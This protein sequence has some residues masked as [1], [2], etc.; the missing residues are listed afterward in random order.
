MADAGEQLVEVP[1]GSSALKWVLSLLAVMYVA[2]SLYFLF[3][4]RERIDQVGKSQAASNGQIAELGKRM[5][6]AEADSEALAKQ[7]GM[8]KKELADRSTEL[9]RQQH[10][11]EQRLAEEQKQEA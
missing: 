6:S 1:T 3:N 8:T 7:L 10:A 4:L 9:Q 2:G 11:A 5:Q